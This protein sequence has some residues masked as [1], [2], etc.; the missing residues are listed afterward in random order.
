MVM[1]LGS[2]S[3]GGGGSPPEGFHLRRPSFSARLRQ[4]VRCG[5][6]SPTSSASLN[7][8]PSPSPSSHPA[9]LHKD[10]ELNRA[11]KERCPYS[12]ISL[13][14]PSVPYEFRMPL[15]YPRYTKAEYEQ[16]P[17]WLLDRLLEEYGLPARSMGGLEAK[18]Q[19]R[20]CKQ[21]EE[22][23]MIPSTYFARSPLSAFRGCVLSEEQ[24]ARSLGAAKARLARKSIG[25]GAHLNK[26]K[27]VC[28]VRPPLVVV[29][30]KGFEEG[31]R[32]RWRFWFMSTYLRKLNVS[33]RDAA[34]SD[35]LLIVA[36]PLFE[37]L[38]DLEVDRQTYGSQEQDE[39][40]VMLLASGG[41]QAQVRS[42]TRPNCKAKCYHE[43]GGVGLNGMLDWLLKYGLT[44]GVYESGMPTT[45]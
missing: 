21:L 43:I 40:T 17:E 9:N 27:E 45:A 32:S 22:E 35:I 25:A 18:R 36:G 41:C 11:T 20:C 33:Q 3:A 7:G 4:I 44:G 2:E 12:A 15:H 34:V 30:V 42:V 24:R 31:G 1:L 39:N 8:S 29:N 5:G 14:N 26:R 6:S 19:I 16:M 23:A 38:A 10:R 37:K 13:H 28:G